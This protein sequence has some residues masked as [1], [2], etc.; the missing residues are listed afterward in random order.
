MPFEKA[1]R[2]KN[3]PP[4]LFVEIDRK[5]KA[6]IAAGRDVINMGIGDPDTPTPKFIIDAANAANADPGNHQYPLDNGLKAFRDTVAWFMADRYGVTVDPDTE[7]WPLIGVKEGLAHLALAVINPGDLALCPDPAYPVYKNA[8]M[9]AGGESHILP[10]KAE[11]R[12]LPDLDGI[13]AAVAKRAKLLW[14]NYPNNPTGAVA[15]AAFYEKTVAFA[16]ANDLVIAQDAPYNEMFFDPADPPRSILQTPGAKDVAIEFHSFSKTF[17][18][19]GWRIGFAVGNKDVV[20]ALGQL[21]SNVDSGVFQAVQVAGIAAL[22]GYKRPEVRGLLDMYRA[23]RDALV[24]G[25][26]DLG[27]TVNNPKATFYVWVSCPKGWTSSAV[28]AR[29]LDEADI[30]MTPGNGFGPSGEGYVRAALTVSDARMQQAIARIAKL[31]W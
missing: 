1:Q 11:N 13:P 5:K 28:S 9:F 18:M 4:Y 19:T 6:A 23:R 30:V 26:Q 2:L 22:K 12:F 31:K 20:A 3:L 25:L 15:D 7:V 27:F 16:K 8:T 10:L 24:K 21:K 14:T 29:L 17:N